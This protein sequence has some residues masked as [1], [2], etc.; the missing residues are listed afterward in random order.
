M[1]RSIKNLALLI[2]VALPL[3][4]AGLWLATR[5]TAG[6]QGGSGWPE[7]SVFYFIVLAPQILAGGV[8]HQLLL[9]I[10]SADWPRG[11]Q[12]AFVFVTSFVVP[13]ILVAFGGSPMLLFA[14]VNL[15]CLGSGLLVYS[16]LAELPARPQVPA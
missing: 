2:L 11:G 3:W 15:L 12:R 16:L 10:A 7:A 6:P 13:V 9:R 14:P 5:L 8:V 1:I 4:L